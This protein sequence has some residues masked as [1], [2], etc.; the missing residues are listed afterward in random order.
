MIPDDIVCFDEK[1]GCTE[2]VP[3]DG[4]M[5][6][7]KESGLLP[8]NHFVLKRKPLLKMKVISNRK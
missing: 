6:C 1:S 3:F 4:L 5:Q 2:Y 8:C 7:E